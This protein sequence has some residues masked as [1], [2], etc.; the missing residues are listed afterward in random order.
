MNMKRYSKLALMSVA[1]LCCVLTLFSVTYLSS[2]AQ[3]TVTKPLLGTAGAFAV[4]GASTITN[5]G[6]SSINGDLGVSPGTAITGFPP[7]IVHGAMHKADGVALQAQ[8]DVKTAYNTI[9]GQSCSHA[10]TGQDLGNKTLVS[11]VY[12]FSSSAQ[13]TGQLTL[14]GQGN[15]ASVF[16]FQI[17]S[18]LTTATSASVVLLH[19][20]QPCNIFWQVGSSATIGTTTSF[21][22]NILALASITVNT[23][24]TS[25][26]SL[27]A[28]TGAVTLDD[29]TIT[30]ASCTGG[31]S[32]TMP[33]HTPTPTSTKTP[34]ATPTKVPGLP[35]TGSDPLHP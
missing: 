16:L 15:P 17:G 22:G 10:L 7:G 21:K 34:V 1:L 9:A 5:T 28:R 20:A 19:D 6:P 32:T 12:C 13:L 14:D 27:Y 30:R 26:G 8:N 4:L 31:V 33:V 29:N 3:N 25:I 2:Y 35:Q 11:G 24:A 23:D 18:T